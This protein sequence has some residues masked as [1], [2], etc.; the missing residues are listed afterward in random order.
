MASDCVPYSR[1]PRTT[2]LHLDYLYHFERVERFYNGL[3]SAFRSFQRVAEVIRSRNSGRGSLVDVLTRQNQHFGC[4]QEALLNIQLLKDPDTFAVVTGQ[5]AG[6]FSGPALTLYKALTAARLA[7]HLTDQGLRCVPVFWLATEDH[8]LEEVLRTTVLDEEGQIR[9]LEPPIE[10]PAAN[11]PVGLVKFGDGITEVLADLER[12]LPSGEARDRLL[13]DLRECYIP[14]ASWGDGFGRFLSRLLGKFGVILIDPLDA[15]LHAAATEIYG[16][17]LKKADLLRERLRKRSQELIAAG[18]HAQVHVGEDST[19]VFAAAN[20]ARQAIHEKDGQFAAADLPLATASEI[21]LRIAGRALD[22]TPSALFRPVVQ[23]FLLPTVA[24]V[25]GPA[26][27]A[28]FAQ[29]QVIYH[30]FG[31]PMPV[32]FPRAAFTLA[33]RRTERLLEKY[34]LTLEDIFRGEEDVRR[35]I[36]AASLSGGREEPWPARLDRGGEEVRRLFDDL[37]PAVERLDPTLQDTLRRAQEKILFHLEKLRGKLSR[38]EIEHSEVLRRHQE[39]LLRFLTPG[40]ALQERQVGGVYFLG[41][42]GYEL[43]DRLFAQIQPDCLDHQFIV[44]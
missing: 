30:E 32:I 6:L 33:D 15:E 12:L 40:G 10:R 27:L 11:S 4:S 34:A 25:A 44:Y 29:S 20:G 2:A 39:I 26:E 42:A 9:W 31:Q 22:F 17:A 8:D 38:A 36:A 13:L 23:D 21:Q 19:L 43:L 14:G 24:Y 28:Y 7:R 41:R 37:R 3:P 16:R 18:Y 5:Q 1:V 35:K